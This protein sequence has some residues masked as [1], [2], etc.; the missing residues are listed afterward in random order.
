MV[1][2]FD[3]VWVNFDLTGN[4]FD[5]T[6]FLF[7]LN[8]TFPYVPATV[9]HDLN[10]TIP[11]N[12]PIQF[13]A[14]G[15]LPVDIYWDPNVVYRLEFRKG[16]TQNDP[17]IYLVPN[18]IAGGG[19]GPTPPAGN[20]LLSSNQMTNQQFSIVSFNPPTTF[21]VSGPQDIQVAPGWVLSVTGTG[22][23]I[24]DIVPLNDSA[25][26][27]TPTNAPYAL[28]VE[29][30]GTVTGTLKQRFN[31]NGSLWGNKTVSSSITAK[32]DATPVTISAVLVDSN[33]TQMGIVLPATV[34]S[35][36]FTEYTGFSNLAG[37]T[38]PDFP[39]AAWVEYQLILP[40]NTNVYVSSFQLVSGAVP[41]LTVKYGEETVERQVDHA[42]HYYAN[43]LLIMPKSS[44][45]AGWA[46]GLNPWQFTSTTPANVSVNGYI[47]D[48]TLIVQQNYVASASGN[49]ISAGRASFTQNYG[50][51]VTAVTALNQFGIIQYIDPTTIRPYWGN[52][53]SA[54]ATL[55]ALKKT[56]SNNLRLKARLLY[57]ASL[58]PTISQTEPVAT[59]TAG[60]EP[61]Y[62][63]G[64][65]AI[66]PLN[67]PAY[68]LTNG[69]NQVK[70]ESFQLPASSNANMTLALVLYTVDSMDSTGTPD[71]IVFNNV[72][73]TPNDF[74]VD[75]NVLTFDEE[76]N[77]CRYY[78]QKSFPQG[79]LPASGAG[80]SGSVVFVISTPNPNLCVGP[81]VRFDTPMRGT[82]IITSYNP[83]GA[84]GQI[85]SNG[86]VPGDW[87]GTT[88]QIISSIGF[89]TGGVPNVGAVNGEA[90]LV[91]YTAA[92]IL[93]V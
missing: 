78:F 83:N 89:Y 61:V 73:L 87:T 84:G 43:S 19:S 10:G 25:P 59:W 9:Y 72:S 65:T 90:C 24:L 58:P 69:A 3:P 8:N 34:L 67:D 45:L 2:S 14:N 77:R 92:A 42:F 13:L 63:A 4:L 75:C 12:N 15:T 55:S 31:Q 29:F 82:P 56:P 26:D 93:G 30:S 6:F 38:N 79:T 21:A 46:F 57:R 17:L 52:K 68:N 33:S 39:P 91:H 71:N 48:Q 32:V 53:L 40:V 62:A 5:D 64:W 51:I 54:L 41:D 76:L 47:A 49:N 27:I 7:V 80:L 11:W 35:T 1:R 70:F 86:A 88:A 74:A 16:N 81:I 37:T 23:A 36:T 22:N 66:A 50:F 18:Y 20:S 28:N 44:L 85:F 60:G